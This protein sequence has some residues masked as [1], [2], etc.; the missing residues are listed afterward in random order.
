MV[1][2]AEIHLFSYFFSLWQAASCI[3]MLYVE[4]YIQVWCFVDI[5][6]VGH[7]LP[8]W[9]STVAEKFPAPP[10]LAIW[11]NTQATWMHG[12]NILHKELITFHLLRYWDHN[13]VLTSCESN[14][15]NVTIFSYVY[16]FILTFIMVNQQLRYF[17]PCYRFIGELF[18]LGMLTTNIMQRC[19]KD[20]LTEQD[21]ESLECLCK[22]L[23]T[24]GKEL[25]NKN[26]V[27][28]VWYCSGS[29]ACVG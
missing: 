22:L 18:K 6:R 25:E 23:T 21:E 24:V 3:Q 16:C 4:L 14:E 12:I 19:I 17:L 13:N 9:H 20:L 7:F 2:S 27:C 29:L 28:C 8:Y 10:S 1:N 15:A 26:Q 11:H 5:I